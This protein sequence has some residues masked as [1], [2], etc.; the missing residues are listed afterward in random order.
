[1]SRKRIQVMVSVL[2]TVC[3]AA[4]GCGA[5][6]VSETASGSKQENGTAEASG[7]E[8]SG[9]ESAKGQASDEIPV[10]R[11]GFTGGEVEEQAYQAGLAG[12]EE[13]FGCKIEWVRYPDVPTM[14]NNLPAQI[15]AGTA[16]D[17]VSLTNENY[18]EFVENG[19]F[20]DMSP[21]I[22]KEEFDFER[23]TD[24]HKSWVIKDGIYGIPTD[25]A[26]A[27]FIVNMDMWEA[28]GLGEL[29]K[30]MEEVKEAAK[31]LTK[32][33]VKGLCVNNNEFHLTQYVLSY[34][35]GWGMG[36]TIDTPENAAGLQFII[37]LYREG[38]VITP[39]EAGL[40]W[41]GEVFGK[42]LCAMS[43]GGVWYAATLQELAPDMNYKI[44]PVPKGTVNGC[45]SHSDATA[46]ISSTKYPELASKICAY[47]G[48]EEAQNAIADLYGNPP[49]FQ[50]L[51]AAFFDKNEGIRELVPA[52]EY[53]QPFGYPVETNRFTD[54]LLKEME[55]ALYVEGSNKTGADIVANV[56]AAM[57]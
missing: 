12:A 15:A 13:K 14:W 49:A 17:L 6:K 44:I 34:G 33:G 38:L 39:E 7:M 19:M 55:E 10:I 21:Y 28:A 40:G 20:L 4:A 2:L 24:V 1:M 30:T 11:Y 54:S 41:D 43:T 27:A 8:S 35:G 46:V 31:A 9:T 36:E 26:P 25:G 51:Q 48:R 22:T 57:K 32:D 56:N 50:D 52:L 37:D 18:L 23:V 47:M 42:G 16:P 3:L 53:A 29:P 45:T 5:P